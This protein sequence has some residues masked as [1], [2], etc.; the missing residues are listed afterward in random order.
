MF[1]FEL[2]G[3]YN[4]LILIISRILF[5]NILE[6]HRLRIFCS[7]EFVYHTLTV[8]LKK[9]EFG[10]IDELL[11]DFEVL[12]LFISRSQL[13]KRLMIVLFDTIIF[14]DGGKFSV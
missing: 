1:S 12:M 6:C 7:F 3:F 8:F 11:F 10:N 5:P 13:I 14:Q 4:G 2:D 9:L